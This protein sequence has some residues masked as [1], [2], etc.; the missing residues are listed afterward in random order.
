MRRYVTESLFGHL[1]LL[2]KWGNDNNVLHELLARELFRGDEYEFERLFHVGGQ[3]IQFGPQEFF[4][5]T[6]LGFGP[7]TFNPPCRNHVIPPM[8]LFHTYYDGCKMKTTELWNDFKDE[9]K[10]LG[11]PDQYL[12][13]ANLVIYYFML[14]CRGMRPVDDCAWTLVDDPKR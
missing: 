3:D 2:N 8:S 1:L 10:D 6:E 14:L 13:A 4:L 7:S 12:S 11:T 5:V 9:S